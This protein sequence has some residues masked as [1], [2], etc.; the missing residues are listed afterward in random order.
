MRTQKAKRERDKRDPK[1][2]HDERQQDE[3]K[4]NRKDSER[5][6]QSERSSILPESH[7]T[8]LH[9]RLDSPRSESIRGRFPDGFAAAGA[10]IRTSDENVSQV[11][12]G[13]RDEE[14]EREAGREVK[15]RET[16]SSRRTLEDL[17]DASKAE[18]V[19]AA[20]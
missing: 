8:P 13:R 4:N 2:H 1:R 15:E 16:N 11:W 9:E 18:G 3:E 5:S 17:F 12:G 6:K 10:L 14:R 19:A 20:G 7:Q